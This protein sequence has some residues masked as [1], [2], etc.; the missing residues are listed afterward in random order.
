MF[1]YFE[2]EDLKEENKSLTDIDIEQLNCKTGSIL[3]LKIKTPTF[4]YKWAQFT[5][6]R[7]TDKLE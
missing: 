5:I 2:I 3:G 6:R 1:L 4:K 7:I